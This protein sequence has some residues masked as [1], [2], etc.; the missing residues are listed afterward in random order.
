[1][2]GRAVNFLRTRAGHPVSLLA[3]VLPLVLAIMIWWNPGFLTPDSYI[4][5]GDLVFPLRP[6]QH[7]QNSLSTWTPGAGQTFWLPHA[8]VAFF[9]EALTFGGLPLWIANRAYVVLPTAM[10]GWFT[11]YLFKSIFME[12]R[13]ALGALVASTFVVT[14]PI[15]TGNVS[16]D[17]ANAGFPL[18]LG[19][20]IRGVHSE[21]QWTRYAIY[22]GFASVLMSTD[23]R[24]LYSALLIAALYLIL[25]LVFN[26][27]PSCLRT[28]KFI[29]AS[30]C[31]SVAVNLYWIVPF[32]AVVT[33]P[34]LEQDLLQ[35]GPNAGMWNLSFYKGSVGLLWISRLV[36]SSLISPLSKYYEI[37]IVVF[38]SFM[39]LLLAYGSALSR[40]KRVFPLTIVALIL[41]LLASSTYYGFTYWFYLDLFRYLPGF[42]VLDSP[43]YWLF[44]LRV[45]Y[46]TLIG[47]GVMLVFSTTTRFIKDGHMSQWTGRGLQTLFLVALV[48]GSGTNA[49]FFDY[50]GPVNSA[51]G[52][53]LP[54]H[55]PAA[56][57]PS[58][59]FDLGTYLSQHTT[60]QE[61][62]LNL[63]LTS[64]GYA[65]YTWW[66]YYTMP[67]VV[68][69]VSSIPVLG[70]NA[71]PPKSVLN[72]ADDVAAGDAPS[73]AGL[74]NSLCVNYVLVHKDYSPIQNV[75]EPK[76]YEPYLAQMNQL[77]AS[78][79][80]S[81]VLNNQYFAL[82]QLKSNCTPTVEIQRYPTDA[83]AGEG[84]GYLLIPNSGSLAINSSITVSA[85]IYPKNVTD[86]AIALKWNG[87]GNTLDNYGLAYLSDGNVW[88]GVNLGGN[89]VGVQGGASYIMKDSWNFVAGV[90]DAASRNMSIY[91]NDIPSE[92]SAVNETGRLSTSGTPLVIG[93]RLLSDAPDMYFNGL[94]SNVQIY[95]HA[96]SPSQIHELYQGGLVSNPISTAE[97]SGQWIVG[98]QTGGSVSD[99][100]GNDN[101]GS[102]QGEGR[103]VN[104]TATKTS[105]VGS[106][107]LVQVSPTAYSMRVNTTKPS[108]LILNEQFNDAWAAT[109]NGLA[110]TQHDST[111]LG[112]NRWLVDETGQLAI[113]IVYTPQYAANL[114]LMI[115]GISLIVLVAY[116]FADWIWAPEKIWRF[117]T[118][119][120]VHG[121]RREPRKGGKPHLVSSEE[122]N[123]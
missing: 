6:L 47:A 102:V 96:L 21:R 113:D 98:T 81:E 69:F 14:A 23:P 110:L 112:T 65:A 87:A 61:R 67:D 20:L 79:Y 31:T 95:N 54:N 3:I 71:Y 25:Y 7:L 44:L 83:F 18:L 108:Y 8:T 85:W 50:N 64:G 42:W 28:T 120:A 104:I 46:G 97:I 53:G 35:A 90:Y 107:T 114:S 45:F 43:Y 93:A 72:A 109:V 92:V 5:F 36:V 115:S 82:Y 74:L 88:F 13:A 15:F 100:S 12:E 89:D 30:I 76:S 26:R 27:P 55:V 62:I 73:V 34:N 105:P 116:V 122:L 117:L 11:F 39:L 51:L 60:P 16:Y 59:Y 49:Y 19:S 9:A 119:T 86:G 37:P 75:F 17:F 33:Q 123:C 101:N 68:G 1:M 103:W 106:Y 121:V 63:P 118:R 99:S 48:V 52:V 22:V 29:L 58:A 4:D 57:I 91:V 38:I 40:D 70:T 84:H 94:I 111:D 78:N 77:S 41:T 24:I 56:E 32:L 10:L 66:N 2:R 80:S